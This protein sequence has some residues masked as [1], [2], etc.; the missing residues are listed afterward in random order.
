[1]LS[2]RL[3]FDKLNNI[4]DLGGMKTADGRTIRPGQLF[5][6]CYLQK[7]DPSDVQKLEALGLSRIVDFRSFNEVKEQPDPVLPGTVNIHLPAEDEQLLG[8][9]RDK[10]SARQFTEILIER[11]IKNPDYAIEY[12]SGM[13]RRFVTNEYTIGQYR[14]FL[15]IV[16]ESPG[17]VLWHCTAGKD[18]AGFAALL[19]EEILG[20]DRESI[21]EDYLITNKYLKEE[22][23][24]LVD[25]F[26]R[27]HG[28]EYPK[29]DVKLFFSAEKAYL[30]ALKTEVEEHW[31]SFDV[32]LRDKMG[33]TEEKREAFRAKYLIP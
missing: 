20:V 31:G 11:V 1:M 30:E 33:V 7:A 12:M 14:K 9:E 4:R 19:L 3:F 29:E 27:V 21:L 22:V 17:P 24:Y 10:D 6:S 16:L 28:G 13:Y 15:E 25:L 2:K 18:R 23:D 32:F 5:R 26:S 8:I